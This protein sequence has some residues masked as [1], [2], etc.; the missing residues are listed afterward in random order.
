MTSR[1]RLPS[2]VLALALLPQLFVLGL[3]RGIVVCVAP[4]GHME[5]EIASACC[6]PLEAPA[7]ARERGTA[8][9]GEDDCGA[10]SDFRL[11]LDPRASRSRA[12]DGASPHPP[13]AP[14]VVWTPELAPAPRACAAPRRDGRV[15]PHLQPLKTVQLRS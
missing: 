15:P 5:V 10:C 12:A 13:A 4:G 2:L 7:S 3:G 1:A 9:S 14:L 11:L 6:S 8:A